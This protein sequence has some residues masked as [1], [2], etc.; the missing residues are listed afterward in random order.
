MKSSYKIFKIKGIS[1]ELH[2]TFLLFFLLLLVSSHAYFLFFALIFTIVLGHE[3]C[4]SF[5]AIREGIYVPRIILV[6]F[7]G[8]ANIEIPE[9]PKLELKVAAAGPAFNV[10]ILAICTAILLFT[11]FSFIGYSGIYDVLDSGAVNLSPDF[12]LSA[13]VMINT[14]L[15]V[16]NIIPAFPLD[17]G[18]IFRSTLALFVDYMEAT[19]FAM[20][21]GKIIFIGMII[22][23][24]L[25]LDFW[26][27][28]I[29]F[30][31]YVTGDNEVKIV[32][33]RHAL[34]KLKAGDVAI[35]ELHY[36]RESDTLHDFL[37][38]S[39]KPNV[40]FYFVKDTA[41]NVSGIVDIFQIHG[42]GDEVSTKNINEIIIGPQTIDVNASVKEEINKLMSSE[43]TIV[44]AGSKIAGYITPEVLTDI[45][46]FY[47][48]RRHYG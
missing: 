25:R 24:I 10:A 41:G 4:H 31:L 32:G 28:L 8:L 42:M 39:A 30:F 5:M 12:I 23:G 46:R 48:I 34:S 17:G 13:L 16:F 15:V 37:D 11:E 22:F 35:K 29:G 47:D 36:A 14:M 9:N 19:K 38:N 21:V 1:V 40:R 6:P 33:I 7:G 20:A 26:I 2:V 3:L 18:R 27:M 44:L 45:A 43:L